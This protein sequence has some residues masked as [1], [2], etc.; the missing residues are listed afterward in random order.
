MKTPSDRAEAQLWADKLQCA[1]NAL[2]TIEDASNAYLD[3]LIT[4]DE[5]MNKIV[6]AMYLTRT[7]PEGG[8]R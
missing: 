1:E 6:S 8:T 7:A 4:S 5:A 3:G 2:R